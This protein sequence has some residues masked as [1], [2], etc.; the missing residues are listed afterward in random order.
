M[1]KQARGALLLRGGR[2]TQNPYE[3]VTKEYDMYGKYAHL[4]DT[5]KGSEKYLDDRD[6]TKSV[7]KHYGILPYPYFGLSCFVAP[8]VIISGNVEV[9]QYATV[10]YG[11][12][13]RSDTNLVRIGAYANILDNC[14]ITE[15]TGPILEEDDHDGSTVI[16]HYVTVGQSSTLESCTIE[17]YCKIGMKCVLLPGSY[18]EEY[19]QL[20]AGSVLRGG[21]RIPTG[22]VWAGNPAKFIRTVSTVEKMHIYKHGAQNNLAEVHR[23]EYYLPP[24]IH[25]KYEDDGVVV[26]HRKPVFDFELIKD[27]VT[28]DILNNRN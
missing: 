16:G 9:W 7:I 20:E 14:V 22:E 17:P 4:F 6:M 2:K 8:G 12:T 18:M 21:M 27:R 10:W 26:A 13:I 3:L 25:Q 19:S 28:D 1:I 11:V 23:D 24:M 15:A 5:K